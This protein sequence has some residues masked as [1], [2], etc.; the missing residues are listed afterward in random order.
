MILEYSMAQPTKI[1]D[2]LN[3]ALKT[4][5][6]VLDF[7]NSKCVPI[8]ILESPEPYRD[9]MYCF[10]YEKYDGTD[11]WWNVMNEIKNLTT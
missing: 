1:H 6:K 3:P 11:W 5:K 8:D 10:G 7:L 9:A 4:A 2:E